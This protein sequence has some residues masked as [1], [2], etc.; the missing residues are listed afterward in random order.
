MKKPLEQNFN[1]PIRVRFTPKMEAMVRSKAMEK[2]MS[3]SEFVRQVCEQY[4]EN[5]FSDTTLINQTLTSQ[6]RKIGYLENKVELMGMIAMELA[7]LVIRHIPEKPFMSDDM[8]ERRME[9]FV[10][11]CS[12]SLKG[13]HRGLL[14]SMVLDIYEQTGGES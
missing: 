4:L 10:E 3:V 2:R 6:S 12:S 9:K 8:V 14:E 7:R 5:Q 1:S 11:D 13:S